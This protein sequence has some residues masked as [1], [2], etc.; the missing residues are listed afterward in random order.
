[1]FSCYGGLRVAGSGLVAL[2]PVLIQAQSSPAYTLRQ[3]TDSA[4]VHYP[5]LQQMESVAS[6][7]QA[8]VTVARH[9]FLPRMRFAEQINAGTDNSIPGGYVTY[10]MVPSVSSGIR[11]DNN[12]ATAA[13]NLSI[14][15][16]DY[17]LV[18]FGYRKAYIDQSRSV[19]AVYQA[20]AARAAY[21][22][23]IQVSRIYFNL[24]KECFRL[25]VNRQNA[26][27]YREIL[28]V[29]QALSGAGL[30]PGSDSAQARA[31]WSKSL[32][33]LEQTTG[34]VI[35]LKE[36][37]SYFTG[38][39]VEKVNIDSSSAH[40]LAGWD[41]KN[42]PGTDSALNPFLEYY[43]VQHRQLQAEQ[44]LVG[45]SFSPRIVIQARTWARGS[46]IGYDD[47]YNALSQGLGYQR[48]NYLAGIAFQYDLFSPL[49]RKD[50]LAVARWQTEA[51]RKA[52]EQESLTLQSTRRQADTSI[53]TAENN[54]AEIPRQ[55]TAA[56]DVYRQKM[57]QYRAGIIN[58]I[59][60]TNAAFVLDRSQNDY[61]ETLADWYLARTEAAWSSGALLP[62]INSI[63]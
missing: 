5:L 56:A 13:G 38:I 17:D 9:A 47:A 58:L 15:S 34:N 10:G 41:E 27:R 24:L 44:R 57:A 45:R 61:V 14:I 6:G 16:A 36:Q 62:F 21:D 12:G 49:H 31:E 37:L 25:N 7:A 53:Q 48:Y 19:A 60:L 11:K 1:M 23:R 28:T 54:L 51:A 18:D 43:Q 59:D 40:W 35:N 22:V 32:T 55:V 39:P 3:L 2:L 30:K 8:S 26:S 50:Q 4:Q 29:I 63:N 33:L 42:P 52:L 20:D 46:S